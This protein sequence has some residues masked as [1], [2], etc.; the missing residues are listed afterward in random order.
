MRRGLL[1]A[2]EGLDKT[3]K[4]THSK[5]LSKALNDLGQAAKNV[6][7]PDRTTDVGKLIDRYLRR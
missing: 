6:R 3:G 7:F 1:I 2:F 4:T 5:L